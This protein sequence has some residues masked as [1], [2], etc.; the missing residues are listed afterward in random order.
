[1][2]QRDKPPS[3]L[4]IGGFIDRKLTTKCWVGFIGWLDADVAIMR[5]AWFAC[6]FG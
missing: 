4:R 3:T 5:A 1:M 2:S 6:H